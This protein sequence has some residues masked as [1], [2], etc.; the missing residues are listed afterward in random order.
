MHFLLAALYPTYQPTRS[1]TYL[2]S[3]F[4]LR[5]FLSSLIL[6]FF[7]YLL[8]NKSEVRFYMFAMESKTT[9]PNWIQIGVGV[10]YPLDGPGQG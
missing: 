2:S 10:P 7:I 6:I 4:T 5:N 9:E 8:N 3:P 1:I